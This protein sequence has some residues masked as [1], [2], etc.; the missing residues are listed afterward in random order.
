[1][2][3]YFFAI[4]LSC[5]AMIHA[6]AAKVDTL[7]VPSA[8]MHKNIKVVIVFP[9]SYFQQ[10]QKQYP[11]VYLLHGYSGN[12]ANWVHDMP[13]S[14]P[15]VERTQAIAV[16]PD[17]GYGSWYFDSP[18]DSTY[19]YETFVAVELPHYIDSHYRTIA[20]RKGRAIA[21]LS[22]GGHG[23]LYLAIKHLEVFGA[24][25][26]M[27]GGVDFTPFPKNW[28]IAKYLGPYEDNKELWEKNTVQNLVGKL[29]NGELAISF[30]CGVDD[31]FIGVN[32]RL[33]ETLAS[34]KI[35]HDYAERPGGHNST[36]W[37]NAISFQMLFFQHFFE[38]K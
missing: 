7:N 3:K 37:N 19:R 30:E 27:S 12:Y 32:R 8:A 35:S 2:K 16:C 23:A 4:L 17:G 1:M 38:R 13:N 34:Q 11:V 14:L 20:D 21:G 28:D 25:A 9:D 15:A 5:A 29:H 36:Y 31:F 33:H 10:S 6:S 26:S 18:V 22:M 24:A